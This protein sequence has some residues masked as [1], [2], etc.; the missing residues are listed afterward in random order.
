VRTL[1][2]P[3]ATGENTYLLNGFHTLLQAGACDVVMPDV[4]RVGGVTGWMQV[5]ALAEAHRLPIASHLFP[6]ISIHLLAASPTAHML[7]YMPW[8][9]PIMA[10]PLRI[11]NGSV[12]LP[13]RPGL[14]L[15]F[16]DAAI[17]RYAVS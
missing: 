16:D 2:V 14:G 7:E 15:V 13:H 8:A 17:E 4:Q 9:Q 11:E 10:E 1:D 6:E 5:A 3:I 12:A